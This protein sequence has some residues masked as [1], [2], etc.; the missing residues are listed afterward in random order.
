MGKGI[1]SRDDLEQLQEHQKVEGAWESGQLTED[2]VSKYFVDIDDDIPQIEITLWPYVYLL[3]A[4]SGRSTSALPPAVTPLVTQVK[5]DRK[6]FLYPA[7]KVTMP[8]SLLDPVPTGSI[9]VGSLD[10]FDNHITLNPIKSLNDSNDEESRHSDIWLEFRSYCDETLNNVAGDWIKNPTHYE[11]ASYSFSLDEAAASSATEKI[12]GLLD[13]LRANNITTPLLSQIT[14]LKINP[15]LAGPPLAADTFTSRSGH[16]TPVYPLSPSQRIGLSAALVAQCGEVVALNGPPGTGKTTLLLSVLASTIVNRALA[17]SDPAL[18]V[19]C[20]TNNQAITNILDA[21]ATGFKHDDSPFGQRWLPDVVSYGSYFPSFSKQDTADEDGH[22]T[23]TFFNRVET[24]EYFNHAKSSLLANAAEAL[25]SDTSSSLGNVATALN[26]KLCD[27]QQML[28]SYLV[29]LQNWEASVL[30]LRENIPDV[31]NEETLESAGHRIARWAKATTA[32]EQYRVSEPILYG[33]F[34]WLPPVRKKRKLRANLFIQEILPR[35]EINVEN[36]DAVSTW[37]GSV[38]DLTQRHHNARQD[39]WYM[40]AKLKSYG[41]KLEAYA[42]PTL[43]EL[44]DAC[45]V[46]IRFRQFQLAGRYW[47]VRWLE[48]MEAVLPFLHEQRKKRGRKTVVPRW[49]RRMMLTPCSVMTFYKA[50]ENFLVRIP[51]SEQNEFLNDYLF[52]EIDLLIVD[53]AGQVGPDIA[54]ATFALAKKALVVGDCQQLQPISETSPQLDCRT[55]I[56]FGLAASLDDYEDLDSLGVTV[57][58]GSIMKHAQ[59]AGRYHEEPLLDRGLYLFEH[60]RCYDEI[61][62]YCNQLSYQGVLKPL[63]GAALSDPVVPTLGLAHVDGI[64]ETN[65]A[66]SRYNRLEAKAVVNWLKTNQAMIKEHYK[67]PIEEIVAVVTPF[68]AQKTLILESLGDVESIDEK[69]LTVG[70]VHSLQGAE[71]PI[72]IFSQ[73]YSVHADGGFI[74]QDNTM[75]N[76]AV[77]RAKDSFLVFGDLHVMSGTSGK[78]PRRQLYEWMVGHGAVELDYG[79]LDARVDLTNARQHPEVEFSHLVDFEQHDRFLKTVLAGNH[80]EVHIVSPFVL[81][82]TMQKCGVYDVLA[83]AVASGMSVNVYSDREFTTN[84][85]GGR[86][87]NNFKTVS[88]HLEKLDVAFHAVRSVHSKLIIADRSVYCVGS[89]NWFSASRNPEFANQET[90]LVYRGRSLTGEIDAHLANLRKRTIV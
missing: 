85:T 81:H 59:V 22:Q 50:P 63:R 48:E 35:H 24:V 49:R 8:R 65:S 33:L 79:E 62:G 31:T 86:P 6:G 46:T 76:V 56:E 52:N 20:S 43:A 45:D 75:L 29:Y 74:D 61:I 14:Q 67:L 2:T 26:K 39:V 5:L 64:C 30:A 38:A 71:R 12:V 78:T 36:H 66:R 73:V 47:E 44:D 11:K 55:S 21:F 53:E 9:A 18:I 13:H 25:P 58:S 23:T 10:N 69:K 70:T 15:T 1:F 3:K 42:V 41:A 72:V 34:S 80:S 4:E 32:W 37:L 16:F 82:Q 88:H 89:F 27:S 77:S 90:S 28:G 57:A 40:V 87:I 7:G 51:G 60:R 17:K 84:L 19:C 54:G 83:E 68:A